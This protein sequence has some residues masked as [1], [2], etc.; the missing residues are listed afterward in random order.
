LCG[1]QVDERRPDVAASQHS[2]PHELC[3]GRKATG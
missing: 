3:H 2:D 1:D